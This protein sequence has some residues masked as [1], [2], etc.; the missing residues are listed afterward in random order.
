MS[1]MSVLITGHHNIISTHVSKTSDV[2]HRRRR[3]RVGPE[4]RVVG[5]RDVHADLVP[6]GE[7]T[8]WVARGGK[9]CIFIVYECARTCAKIARKLIF[10]KVSLHK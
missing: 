2:G 5:G 4:A 7:D 1:G 9:Q 10:K 8:A 6:G 3:V